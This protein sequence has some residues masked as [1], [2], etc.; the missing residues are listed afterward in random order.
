MR[1]RIFQQGDFV[2]IEAPDN[3]IIHLGDVPDLPDMI[4]IPGTD[5]SE[6]V[7]LADS[8]AASAARQGLYG[9]HLV[10]TTSLL[11]VPRGR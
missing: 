10:E 1:I 3:A 8:V 2:L 5:G 11:A 9:L 4:E 6:G 7:L